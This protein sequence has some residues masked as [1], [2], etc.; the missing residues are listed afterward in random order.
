MTQAV[1]VQCTGDAHRGWTCFATIR[2]ARGDVSEHQVRV[3]SADL[4][5]L[6]PGATDPTDLVIRSIAFLLEREPPS[7]I[8]RAFD[9][10]TIARFY[11]EYLTTI[12]ATT[13]AT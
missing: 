13:R 11:P 10:V 5:R 4:E 7:S 1:D 8:L 6:A 12:R 3:A 9:L 2:T